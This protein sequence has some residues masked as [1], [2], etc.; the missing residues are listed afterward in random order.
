MGIDIILLTWS[1]AKVDEASLEVYH[2]RVHHTQ[3][4][5]IP[6]SRCVWTKSDENSSG[7]N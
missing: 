1:Q 2:D 6:P 5:M 7:L 3:Y 4:W